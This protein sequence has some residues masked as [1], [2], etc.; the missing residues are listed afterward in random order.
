MKNLSHCL[1][2]KT[3]TMASLLFPRNAWQIFYIVLSPTPHEVWEAQWRKSSALDKT[4]SRGAL[5]H[6]AGHLIG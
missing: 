1:D 4:Y 2:Y 6:S 5:L 3:P